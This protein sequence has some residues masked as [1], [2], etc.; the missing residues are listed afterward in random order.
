MSEPTA[1]RCRIEAELRLPGAWRRADIVASRLASAAPDRTSEA[2]AARIQAEIL[3]ARA[4]EQRVTDA[5]L[6]ISVLTLAERQA[7]AQR[8]EAALAGDPVRREEARARDAVMQG[9]DEMRARAEA[10]G[11][12]WRDL[13]IVATAR[14]RHAEAPRRAGLLARLFR[15]EPDNPAEGHV[16]VR[17][18]LFLEGDHRAVHRVVERDRAML[19]RAGRLAW[20]T[21]TLDDRRRRRRDLRGNEAIGGGK[22]PPAGARLVSLLREIAACF[23]ADDSAGAFTVARALATYAQSEPA[24]SRLLLRDPRSPHPDDGFA[25]DEPADVDFELQRTLRALQARADATGLRALF[26]A[27]APRRG[28]LRIVER[29]IR[30]A[31]EGEGS[32]FHE[33]AFAT[34]FG[35]P[36]NALRHLETMQQDGLLLPAEPGETVPPEASLTAA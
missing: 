21:S 36:E 6:G 16:A 26:L 35:S 24:V 20:F 30:A 28:I 3:A 34:L 33:P 13:R 2:V 32:P 9:L 15:R 22:L 23:A 10:D 27:G 4:P 18:S 5:V 8:L 14:L 19:E 17:F 7:F 29:R 12:G 1:T 25:G 31:A 11:V